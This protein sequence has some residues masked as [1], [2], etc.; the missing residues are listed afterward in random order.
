[1]K[2]LLIGV[3]LLTA[4]QTAMAQDIQCATFNPYVKGKQHMPVPVKVY[5]PS[6]VSQ[7][8][9]QSQIYNGHSAEVILV[10]ASKNTTAK[11]IMKYDG[12]ITSVF[13]SVLDPHAI[14]EAGDHRGNLT[15][16]VQ[17][18]SGDSILNASPVP[19]GPTNL[20]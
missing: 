7:S 1:M 13:F 15:C 4:T 3:L 12:Q 9:P 18:D 8:Q 11:L 19:P 5:K 16:W 14:Y 20:E 6:L 17:E 2:N 10:E